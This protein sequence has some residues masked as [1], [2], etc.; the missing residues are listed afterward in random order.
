MKTLSGAGG[1][2]DGILNLLKEKK[3]NIFLIGEAKESSCDLPLFAS[4]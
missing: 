1:V 2:Q 3:G 4:S